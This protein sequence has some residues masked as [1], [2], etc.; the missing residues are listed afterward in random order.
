MK[1]EIDELKTSYLT[2]KE[3]N[4]SL[5]DDISEKLEKIKELEL[6]NQKTLETSTNTNEKAS[7]EDETITTNNVI[8]KVD[9]TTEIP[10]KKDDTTTTTSTTI[11]LTSEKDD[12][13]N[14]QVLLFININ[15]N[16]EKGWNIDCCSREI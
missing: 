7:K 14:N 8:E 5:Q 16:G 9:T 2:E 4:K 3:T 15:N 6:D 1:T 10:F 12:D 13:S 11:E